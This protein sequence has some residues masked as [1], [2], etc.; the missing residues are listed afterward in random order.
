[1]RFPSME[2]NYKFR[3]RVALPSTFDAEEASAFLSE[4]TV[5]S[6]FDAY[7]SLEDEV[8][9]NV[10]GDLGFWPEID[11][12]DETAA[13]QTALTLALIGPCKENNIPFVPE[14]VALFNIRGRAAKILSWAEK[15]VGPENCSVGSLL[16]RGEDPSTGKKGSIKTRNFR[17]GF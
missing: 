13:V 15:K 11:Y 3:L 4:L 8:L 1:M 2:E 6:K 5:E 16:F 10:V 9:H 14:A 17:Y 12:P 7:F